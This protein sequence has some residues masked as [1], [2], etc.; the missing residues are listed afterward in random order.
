MIEAELV[1]LYVEAFKRLKIDVEIKYNSRK[2]MNGLILECGVPDEL[3]SKTITI[4]DK[5]EKLS[6]EDFVKALM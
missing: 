2:L 5:I 1:S 6:K 4:I 3:T